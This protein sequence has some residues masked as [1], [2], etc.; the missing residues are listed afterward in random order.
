MVFWD[1]GLENSTRVRN[2]N[3][4]WPKLKNFTAFLKEN[5]ID[6]ECKIY[7]FSPTKIIKD[8]IH[9]PFKLGEFKK[10]EK[11]NIV[12]NENMNFDYV[13][14]HDSDCFFLEKNYLDLLNRIKS[15]EPNTVCTYD[16]LGL[17]EDETINLINTN[18]IDLN[19]INGWYAYSGHRFTYEIFNNE[20]KIDYEVLP[21]GYNNNTFSSIEEANEC[22]RKNNL[23][24]SFLIRKIE[25]TPLSTNIGGVGCCC[26]IDIN[27]ILGCGGFNENIKY[28]GGEDNDVMSRIIQLYSSNNLIVEPNRVFAPIHLNHVRDTAN[29]NYWGDNNLKNIKHDKDSCTLLH[30]KKN[31][32]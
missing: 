28:W 25:T 8:S 27:L 17:N 23:K 19:K 21:N 24:D 18:E 2:V 11:L 4:T 15:I 20:K 6:A 3:F 32:N 5:K 14:Q 30:L 12:Y 9:I 7:D 13:F 26:L 1:D 29:N 31:N 10:S 16:L 22:I